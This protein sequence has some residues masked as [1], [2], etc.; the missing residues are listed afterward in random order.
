MTLAAACSP[1]RN[2]LGSRCAST[3][4][5][6]FL[7]SVNDGYCSPTTSLP[8]APQGRRARMLDRVSQERPPS[9]EL[10]ITRLSV[11]GDIADQVSR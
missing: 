2:D 10:A 7:A 8:Q 5:L 4:A 1:A 11:S 3:S 6:R 9:V